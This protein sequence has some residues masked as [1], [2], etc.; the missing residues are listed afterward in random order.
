M[1][2]LEANYLTNISVTYSCH[3]SQFLMKQQ[4]KITNKNLKRKKGEVIRTVT[5]KAL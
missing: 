4:A 5:E 2:A 1:Y 3:I